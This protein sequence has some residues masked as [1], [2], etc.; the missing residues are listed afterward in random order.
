MV[1][2]HRIGQV[3]DLPFKAFAQLVTYL[4]NSPTW[5]VRLEEG[6]ALLALL[7]AAWLAALFKE[8]PGSRGHCEGRSPVDS[9]RA[10][11]AWA[12]VTRASSTCC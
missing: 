11:P 5:P 6:K 8:L 7:L 9:N 1:D 4:P 12:A 2:A 3:L 10:Q